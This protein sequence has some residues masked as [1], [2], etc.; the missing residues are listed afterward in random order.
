MPVGIYVHVPF[1]KRK[2]PY[3]D[4]YSVVSD[5]LQ[6][7]KYTSA[8]VN[9][10]LSYSGSGICVDTV[11]FGG[12]TPSLLSTADIKRILDALS[13]AFILSDNCEIT[14][15]C[16]PSSVDMDKF[17]EYSNIG[18]NRLSFGVQ[19][20]NDCE[21]E[22]L[23]R[24]HNFSSA[25]KAVM[26]AK[27]VGFQNI[28]CDLMI[29]TPLQTAESLSKSVEDICSL[30]V[31]HI[32]CYMLKIEE[33]TPYDCDLI[34]KS[35]ADDDVVSDMYIALCK[36]LDELGFNQYEI[37]NFSQSGFESKHNLKYWHCDEYI[38]FGPSAHS[39]YN[40]K[41]TYCDADV[42]SF[43]DNPLIPDKTEELDVDP[44]E[45]YIMLGLRLSE[46]I[47]MQRI[48]ELGGNREKLIT[49]MKPYVNAGF[50]SV[51]SNNVRLTTD[52]FLRSN[53]I[54]GMAIDSQLG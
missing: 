7:Q 24:L 21:L 45:E 44:L 12:G 33:G 46:G 18:I 22:K 31:T 47:S 41:R 27:A 30:G 39:F 35:V 53:G 3:C 26:D 29:G 52:G 2:C 9:R 14:L 17:S 4:F 40:G 42:L 28:S 51:S 43:I 6:M 19:S 25:K 54:I 10:I 11:Y 13:C 20:S 15:E 50:A 34:R 37:S 49:A 36:K 23:G 8:L 38:G 5:D 16:N 32:S 48:D 1:C